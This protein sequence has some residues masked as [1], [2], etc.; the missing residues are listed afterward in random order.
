MSDKS[1]CI[2][3][4]YDEAAK[5]LGVKADSVRR[6]ASARKWPKRQGN[7]GM[8]R[9]GVP[10]SIIPDIPPALPPVITPDE[11]I[12]E[13]MVEIASLRA[14]MEGLMGRLADTQ[15]E[16]DRLAALLDRALEPRPV[17][18]RGILDRIFGR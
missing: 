9:V 10:S 6:R 18:Q 5:R 7:D 4:T 1:E 16:R 15:A 17:V 11:N 12:T 2:F 3:L 14:K 8:A 13:L